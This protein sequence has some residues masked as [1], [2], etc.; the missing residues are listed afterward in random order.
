MVR[1][2]SL[3]C[4]E[5]FQVGTDSTSESQ[6][7]NPFPTRNPPPF[8]RVDIP[9]PP[10]LPQAAI[11]KVS[12]VTPNKQKT[13]EKNLGE[14]IE[15]DK[16]T[17]TKPFQYTNNV[18]LSSY[19]IPPQLSSS[20]QTISKYPLTTTTNSIINLNYLNSTTT[21]SSIV[22]P[23]S[24]SSQLIYTSTDS[25]QLQ[26]EDKKEESTRLAP[27]FSS[28][29][30]KIFVEENEE[31]LELATLSAN[32]PDEGPGPINYVLLAGDQSLFR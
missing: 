30:L 10:P 11:G 9:L 16:E 23:V 20:N 29:A 19:S 26:I 6:L 8:T 3:G 21:L 32:Y 4:I 28:A 17:T 2:S 5:P 31:Q 12:L 7:L 18:P 15:I 25:P 1:I 22:L 24:S 14:N 13:K 27:I